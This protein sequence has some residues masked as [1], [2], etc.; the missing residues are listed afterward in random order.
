MVL[1]HTN[2]VLKY[3]A[4]YTYIYINIALKHTQIINPG[5]IKF[6]DNIQVN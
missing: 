1:E 4:I 6:I 5:N 3:S 2:I